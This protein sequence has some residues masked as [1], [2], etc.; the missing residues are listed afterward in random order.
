MVCDANLGAGNCIRSAVWTVDGIGS[1]HFQNRNSLAVA[2]YSATLTEHV[3]APHNNGVLDFPHAMG[4]A[5]TPERGAF[6]V[7]FLRLEDDRVRTAQDR[8]Y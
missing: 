4:H 2:K 3:M 6:K 1:R 8:Q 7:L 5:G